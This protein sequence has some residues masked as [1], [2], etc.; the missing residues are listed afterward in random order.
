[1]ETEY[2]SCSIAVSNA[3][4]IGRFVESLN[5]GIPIKLVN[6]FCN[7]KFAISLIKS[8][9]HSFKGKHIDINYHLFKI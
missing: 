2:I 7:N 9:V 4:W 3:V 1:M 6:V 8:G 5:L